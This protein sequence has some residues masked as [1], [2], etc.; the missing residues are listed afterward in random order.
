M[1][2]PVSTPG[3]GN[4]SRPSGFSAGISVRT[5]RWGKIGVGAV[6]GIALVVGLAIETAVGVVI[7]IAVGFAVGFAARVVVGFTV[8]FAVGVAVGFAV[9]MA[10]GFVAD[11]TV[12]VVEVGIFSGDEVEKNVEDIVVTSG[13]GM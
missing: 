8:R 13:V 6:T 4:G 3:V 12:G 11:I 2:A 9:G 7:R 10:T 1:F 5:M